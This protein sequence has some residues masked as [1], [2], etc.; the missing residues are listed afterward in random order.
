MSYQLIGYRPNHQQM[1]EMV[2]H[3]LFRISDGII[4]KAYIVGLKINQLT[5][6]WEFVITGNKEN[7]PLFKTIKSAKRYAKKNNIELI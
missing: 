4:T 5:N 3:Y 6:K 2:G 1:K 7:E